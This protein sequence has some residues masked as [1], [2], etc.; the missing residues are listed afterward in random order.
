[1]VPAFP[2][3]GGRAFRAALWAWKGNLRWATQIA[4]RFGSGFGIVLIV[5]G[6]INLLSGHVVGGFWYV[7]IGFFLYN[8]A[9]QAYAQLLV[10]RVLEG[11]PVRRFMSRDPVTVAPDLSVQTFVDE[12]LYRYLHDM[13]PVSRDS[14]VVGCLSTRQ[15]GKVPRSEWA[16]TPVADLMN[17]CSSENTIQADSDAAKALSKM[18]QT[19]ESRLLVMEGDRLVGILVL[20]DLL[21]LVALRM[22]LEERTGEPS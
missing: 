11:E 2:L 21:R 4:S 8:A 16:Q 14:K 19:G 15:L 20:K 7:L 5:L 12:Y 13:F 6:G 1:M 22:D 9:A 17:P 10:R 3:D 18:N